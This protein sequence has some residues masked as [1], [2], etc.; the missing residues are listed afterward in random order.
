MTLTVDQAKRH[1]TSAIGG[2][3]S[4]EAGQTVDGRLI[5]ILN[6]A[7]QRLFSR[8]WSFRD[9]ASTTLNTVAG[10]NFVA[11]PAGV[12]EVSELYWVSRGQPI[13][14]TTR[15]HMDALR[16]HSSADWSS[17]SMF[18]C[19]SWTAPTDGS[20]APSARIELWPTPAASETGAILLRYRSQWPV[21][22]DA[23]AGTH[24]LPIP[25]YVETL[26]IQ[27]ARVIAQAY[28]DDDWEARLA[29]CDTGP[30][31]QLAMARDNQNQ[32][33]PGRWAAHAATFPE[34]LPPSGPSSILTSG[35]AGSVRWRGPFIGGDV[36]ASGDIV[37]LDGRS[38][39]AASDPGEAIPPAT[40]WQ[41]L[42]DRGRDGQDGPSIP[43]MD[44]ASQAD[45][46]A[47]S[48]S[49]NVFTGA[50]FADGGYLFSGVDGGA[51]A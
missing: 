50:L 13:E 1:I 6:Q 33:T 27:Y 26:F 19:V 3:P 22:S 34:S 15:E 37:S 49:L 41:L 16:V 2:T 35:N 29:Q 31:F 10:Q 25:D 20:A 4:L 5:E 43:L 30:T 8:D 44:V 42:A 11:L 48:S 38:W 47:L 7:G 24:V 21:L 9:V 40:P 39:I 46:L 45:L 28:E 51:K 32:R 23:T 17:G 12:A 14:L 36:Y 18:G